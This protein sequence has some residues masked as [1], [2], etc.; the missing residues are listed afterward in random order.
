MR[1]KV[2]TLLFV[3]MCVQMSTSFAHAGLIGSPFPISTGG[4]S[5][6]ADMAFDTV[7][8]KYLVVYTNY[9]ATPTARV[10]GRFVTAAGVP[11]GSE[12]CFTDPTGGLFGSV[13]YNPTNN[14]FL[15]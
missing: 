1:K 12:L 8:N 7:D 2:A 9:S 3:S 14:M 4:Y 5:R 11:I 13:A 10:C 15:V 6:F